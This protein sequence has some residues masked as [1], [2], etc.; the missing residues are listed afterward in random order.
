MRT[1]SRRSQEGR[2]RRRISCWCEQ[3]GGAIEAPSRP[4]SV[5]PYPQRHGGRGSPPVPTLRCGRVGGH[6]PQWATARDGMATPPPSRSA[7]GAAIRRASHVADGERRASG[8]SRTAAGPH[9]DEASRSRLDL[10]EEEGR[11]RC[12]MMG[13]GPSPVAG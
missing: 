8:A 9:P 2:G 10:I 4:P 11:R 7:A 13:A 5:D 6:A 3:E 1:G 12:Q